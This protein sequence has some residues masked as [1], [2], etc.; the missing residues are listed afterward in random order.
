MHLHSCVNHGLFY[1]IFSDF[2]QLHSYFG[3]ASCPGVSLLFDQKYQHW[4]SSDSC[5]GDPHVPNVP[6]LRNTVDSFKASLAV[7][8]NDIRRI[9]RETVGQRKSSHWYEVHNFRLTASIFGTILRRKPDT[10]PDKLDLSILQSK[11][12]T[13]AATEWGVQQETFASDA[14]V[15]HRQSQ[16][17]AG[18]N[19]STCGFYIIKLIPF[20]EDHLMD[21]YT[22]LY[23]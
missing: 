13:S 23:H 12:F 16:G 8:D 22:I 18:I 2:S 1:F 9:E 14:Y 5:P 7:T 19:V 17:H 6:A 21:V 10:P 4:E 20:W 11:R 3:F 15:K